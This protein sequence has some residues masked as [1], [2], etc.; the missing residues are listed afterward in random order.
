MSREGVRGDGAE[1]ADGAAR[2]WSIGPWALLVLAL[3]TLCL[4]LAGLAST[5]SDEPLASFEPAAPTSS[6]ELTV[7]DP[8]PDEPEWAT[9]D[10]TPPPV[11]EGVR[12]AMDLIGL[13]LGVL[14]GL[15]V[16]VLVVWIAQRVIALGRRER[17]S[18]AAAEAEPE[19][20]TAQQAATALDEAVVQLTRAR[21]PGDAVIAAWLAL[22]QAIAEAG[23]RRGGSQTTREFVLAVLGALS[24]PREDLEDFARLYGRALFSGTPITEADRERAIALLTRLSADLRSQTGTGA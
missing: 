6:R 17:R 14:A 13:V 11:R 20:L 3:G 1:Q 21:R 18:E 24:L 10:V 12:E 8:G 15:V 22:E 16:L 23:I 2:R 9:R 19:E 4:V 5:R 7:Q